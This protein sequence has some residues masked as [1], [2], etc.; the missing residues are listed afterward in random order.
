MLDSSSVVSGWQ[1]STNLTFWGCGCIA[2]ALQILWPLSWKSKENFH[3]KW[4]VFLTFSS[5]WSPAP[6]RRSLSS[7]PR[8]FKGSSAMWSCSKGCGKRDC[9]GGLLV[10]EQIWMLLQTLSRK[11]NW[12]EH[13]WT[14]YPLTFS[15]CSNLLGIPVKV[16]EKEACSLVRAFWEEFSPYLPKDTKV[17]SGAFCRLATRL[18]ETGHENL[19]VSNFPKFDFSTNIPLTYVDV[20][21]REPHPALAVSD[22]IAALDSMKK[23]DTLLVGNRGKQ[24]KQFWEEWRLLQPSHPVFSIHGS[25]LARCIPMMIHADEGTSVKK[26]A[27]MVLQMQPLLGKG[28]RKRK[29]DQETPGINLLGHSLTTRFLFSVMLAKVYSGKKKK[30]RPLMA[31]VRSLCLQLKRCFYDG[32]NVTID[33]VPQ[34][35]F[36]VTVAMKGDWPALSK[37]GNLVRHHGRMTSSRDDGKGICHLCAGGMEGQPWHDISFANMSAMRSGVPAPWNREP[38]LTREIPMDPSCKPQFFKVDIFHTCH[39]GIMADLA[40]NV[41]V[42]SFCLKKYVLLQLPCAAFFL[43]LASF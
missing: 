43:Q 8:F 23:I 19:L 12:F 24:F 31:L 14:Q 20:G 39:K 3:C 18:S 1:A 22:F 16:T 5:Q 21:L 28:S 34:N 27:L 32:I 42:P 35:I 15:A 10:Q 7:A 36:L 37:L 6:M 41:I 13:V 29:G 11:H 9:Q 38:D 2:S 33:D 30:N 4:S 25:H 26:K 17:P 40:A